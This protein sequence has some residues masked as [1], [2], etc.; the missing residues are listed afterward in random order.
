MKSN[1][2]DARGTEIGNRQLPHDLN[3]FQILAMSTK[4]MNYWNR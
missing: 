4:N 2:N 1:L 3:Q